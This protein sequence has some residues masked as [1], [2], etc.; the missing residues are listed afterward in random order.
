M[1]ISTFHTSSD[2]HVRPDPPR[3]YW[4]AA[5]LL[6]SNNKTPRNLQAQLPDFVCETGGIFSLTF[7]LNEERKG[8]SLGNLSRRRVG[9]GS[10]PSL[11]TRTKSWPWWTAS[12]LY[13]LRVYWD[14]Y[15]TFATHINL[16]GLTYVFI[17]TGTTRDHDNATFNQADRTE[18]YTQITP[19]QEKHD[20]SVECETYA[21]HIWRMLIILV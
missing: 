9:F 8:W 18:P 6:L 4:F 5:S 1:S 13:V 21:L 16:Q 7:I 15:S 17:L 2:K 10:L 3:T 12:T 14:V 19:F 20:T 11:R